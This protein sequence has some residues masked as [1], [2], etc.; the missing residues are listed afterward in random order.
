[1]ELKF[2]K[3]V[4]VSTSKKRIITGVVELTN[5]IIVEPFGG[6]VEKK[7]RTQQVAKLENIKKKLKRKKT[8]KS[9]IKRKRII[10]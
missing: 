10:I 2:V 4:L 6:A 7:I 5:L 8:M 1:M 9:G 3:T